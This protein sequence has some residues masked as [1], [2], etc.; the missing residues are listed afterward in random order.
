VI[1]AAALLAACGLLAGCPD[2]GTVRVTVERAGSGETILAVDAEVA[3]TAEE[4]RTGLR[5]HAPL[6]DGDG[7]LIEMPQALDICIVNDGVDFDI[8]A[9]YAA[10]DG[11]VIAVERAIPAGDPTARCQSAVRWVLEVGAGAADPVSAGDHLTP[12]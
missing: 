1:R 12:G 6:G 5:G 7:L 4:R 8:D 9:V 10:G 11:T 3:R 2:A